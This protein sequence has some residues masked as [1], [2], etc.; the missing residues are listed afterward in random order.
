MKTR[1]HNCPYLHRH[2]YCSHKIPHKLRNGKKVD[3]TYNKCED[4]PIWNE[5]PT[6]AERLILTASKRLKTTPEEIYG[7]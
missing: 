5:S 7:Q 3:C 1:P 4:C 6:D 2:R